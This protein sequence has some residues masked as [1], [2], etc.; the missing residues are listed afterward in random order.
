MVKNMTAVFRVILVA[1][2]AIGG[3][4]FYQTLTTDERPRHGAFITVSLP[5]GGH[6]IPERNI[7]ITVRVGGRWDVRDKKIDTTPWTWIVQAPEGD[8]VY[9]EAK[10]NQEKWAFLTIFCTIH[11]DMGHLLD[12]SGGYGYVQCESLV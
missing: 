7:R 1:A 9:V 3:F 12:D 6:M 10:E 4:G 5:G 8:R 2:V 11:N